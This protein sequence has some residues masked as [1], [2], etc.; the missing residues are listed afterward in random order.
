MVINLDRWISRL[1]NDTLSTAYVCSIE[2]FYDRVW[3][4]GMEWISC[5]LFI[6]TIPAVGEFA[7][8]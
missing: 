5:V 8:T 4:N 7:E 2:C 3:W 6:D 1:F